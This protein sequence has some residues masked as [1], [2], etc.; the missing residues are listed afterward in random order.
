MKNIIITLLIM[1]L[2]VFSAVSQEKGKNELTQNRSQLFEASDFGPRQT[3][4]P[5]PFEKSGEP[6]ENVKTQAAISTGYYFVNSFDAADKPWKPDFTFIDTTEDSQNWKRIISGPYQHPKSWYE[7]AQNKNDG[8]RYFRHKNFPDNKD[9][10]DDVYAGPI[11]IGFEFEYNGLTYDSFYVLSNGAI[12]LS[13]AR[14]IYDNSSPPRRK[15]VANNYTTPNCYNTESMDW[16]IRSKFNK[17]DGTTDPTEDDWGWQ[18]ASLLSINPES[19][20]ADILMNNTSNLPVIAPFWGDGYLSQWNAKDTVPRD[21]GK[22]YFYRNS[23]STKLI[24]YFVEMQLKGT[25]NYTQDLTYTLNPN[26]TNNKLNPN[27][28]TEA[29][30]GYI[31]VRGQIVLDKNDSS[32]TFNYHKIYGRKIYSK[33]LVS[34]GKELLRF[35]THSCV[36]GEARH[37]NFDS[38]KHAEDSTYTGTLPWAG[39]YNQNTYVWSKYITKNHTGYP[40]PTQAVKFK[41]WKNTLRAVDIGFRVRKQI[42]GSTAYTEPILTSQAPDFEILAGHEQVGQLQ[43]VVIVQNLTNDIQ[44]PNGVN[45]QP[46]DLNF[47]VRLAIIN[48]ATRR[49]LYNKYLKVDSIRLAKKAGDEAFERV[50]LSKI[51]Y[52]G[53]DY[54]A[55]TMHSDYYDSNNHLK[56]KYN[57]IPPYGFVQIYFPPFE[58]NDLYM[59][60]IGLMKA[61]L[62]LDP[63]DPSTQNKFGDSW[64][65]DDTLNVRFWVMR[66]V[67]FETAWFFTDDISVFHCISSDGN[68]ISAIPSVLKWVSIGAEV[69]DGEQVSEHPLPPRDEFACE[70]DEVFPDYKV[71]SPVIKMDRG[72]NVPIQEW[73]GDEIRSYPFRIFGGAS[74]II[75]SVQ[76]STRQSSWDRGWSDEQLIGCEHRVVASDWYN[77]IQEPDELRIEFA[78]PSP[79]WRDGTGI[80]NIPEENWR[81]HLRRGG[82]E[83]ETNM[84]AYTLFGGGGYMVGFLETDRDSAMTLPRYS[85][86]RAANGLRYDYYDDGIDFEYKNY[87][88]S[89]PDT[90]IRAA[91]DGAQ[92]F[93]FRIKVHAKNNQ[94]SLT[95]IPDDEDPFYIDNIRIFDSAIE[96]VDIEINNVSIEWPYTMVPASQATSIPIR[97]T[98]NNNSGRQAPSF[99]VQARITPKQYFDEIYFINDKW[100]WEG[101]PDD[102]DYEDKMDEFRY[103]NQQS[104]DSARWELCNHSVYCRTKQMPFLRPGSDEPITMPNWNAKLSPPGDYAILAFIYVPGGDLGPLND[105]TYS[106][107]NIRFGPFMSYHPI[108]DPNNVRR[109]NSD[110]ANM[111]GWYGTGL[112]L[113]G[114][115]MGGTSYS[116]WAS[117][118]SSWEAGD[119]SGDG[120]AGQIAMKFEL[121][122]EDTLFGYGAAHCV[123][124]AS[125]DWIVFKLYD[126]IS[127]PTNEIHGSYLESRRGYDAI[128]DSSGIWNQFAFDLLDKPIILQKGT[129]WISISQ[130]G[131][132]GLALGASKSNVGMRCTNV[133]FNDPP[134]SELNGSEGIYLNLE[135]NY[136]LR[137]KS[138]NQLNKNL[139]SYKNG[140]GTGTWQPFMETI[141]NPG[142]PHLMH[143]GM[144]PIDGITETYS[145]GTWMPLL[146]PYFGNRSYSSEYGFKFC[147]PP[148]ELSY[149]R[150]Y[151]RKGVNELLWETAS[152]I[153][154]H[155][156]F[157]ERRIEGN[158]DWSTLPEFIKGH[159]TSNIE[160]EYNYSDKD[161]EPNKTYHYRLRQVDLDGTQTD[162][163]F[164]GIVTLTYSDKDGIVLEQ[165]SPNPFS[166]TTTFKFSLPERMF[167]RLDIVDILGNTVVT[168]AE[169]DLPAGLHS[170][171]WN[172][173]DY[174]GRKVST[175]TYIYRLRTSSETLTNKLIIVNG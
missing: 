125:P 41:Q 131:E 28:M 30:D 99:W 92:Y 123:K 7:T 86:P 157:I 135:K 155:G 71:W 174:F 153:Q 110:V 96:S 21:R 117:N 40:E 49:P 159:G 56:T 120:G 64:P 103:R 97:V 113:H 115:S 44:G 74:A 63:T 128:W 140:L 82:A 10:V 45:Y 77:V 114:Y 111:I 167:V 57:G 87:W 36:T 27:Y 48:Q 18:M 166:T 164:S 129:Y 108:T 160:H 173:L 16:F 19:N 171:T 124:S 149:F 156:F 137:D 158:E 107:F 145:R 4:Y 15:V 55:D 133:Y 89:I 69:M 6:L 2:F 14:Y 39:T 58:P 94:R 73:G 25:L 130:L 83:T 88:A 11:P 162:D 22:V 47:R 101:S 151:T 20:P 161:I 70:N 146:V 105:T 52:D 5:Y 104:R 8:Y 34:E 112:S 165:N 54:T 139:F 23:D 134:S 79:N 66:N 144:S 75:I 90:F 95:S 148:V 172:G 116:D 13:N 80:T 78:K 29:D 84:S 126:G 17:T 46:Q 127:S 31:A 65:F 53:K 59:S 102:P 168:L 42:A 24:I 67:P 93:R 91:N 26:S 142:Y 119:P 35:N 154:N 141:G 62:M 175:G 9:S 81:Y 76:R 1:T 43:P 51:S 12:M 163:D 152:E 38:K 61:Y 132:T 68:S 122:K 37:L 85:E 98:L 33:Y 60:N 72:S 170:L 138:S 32:I 100:I 147:C 169:E 150:G 136:R 121:N 109:A 118:F 143:T 50:I 106:F 3:S